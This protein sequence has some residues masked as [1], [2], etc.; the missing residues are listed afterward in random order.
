MDEHMAHLISRFDDA[1]AAHQQ[2]YGIDT[3]FDALGALAFFAGTLLSQAPDQDSRI[4]AHRYF[5]QMLSDGLQHNE[6][7]KH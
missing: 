3:V 6:V 7:T 1:L 5:L 4:Q 2:D